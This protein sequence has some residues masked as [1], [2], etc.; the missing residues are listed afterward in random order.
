MAHGIRSSAAQIFWL[1]IFRLDRLVTCSPFS[2]ATWPLC[3]A[4]AIFSFQSNSKSPTICKTI[5]E[6]AIEPQWKLVEPVVFHCSSVFWFGS[7]K[8]WRLDDMLRQPRA[9]EF[10]ICSKDVSYYVACFHWSF[11]FVMVQERQWFVAFCCTFGT[12]A[13]L[14]WF[15]NSLAHCHRMLRWQG[16]SR[17]KSPW[18]PPRIKKNSWCDTASDG[19]IQADHDNMIMI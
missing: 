11:V 4:A 1:H 19:A 18:C 6:F 14:F 7:R 3:A 8:H 10:A 17:E 16:L 2:P 15:R 13:S 5:Q 9:C 12:D